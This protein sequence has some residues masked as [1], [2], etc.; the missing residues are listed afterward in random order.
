[1]SIL[2]VLA[3]K[4]LI[5]KE[6]IPLIIKDAQVS[7]NLFITLEKY[8][9]AER[10]Y[11]EAKGEYFGMPFIDLE[12][13]EIPFD[14]LSYVPEESAKFYKIAPIGVED[15]VLKIGVVDPENVE[16]QNAL[17]FIASRISMPVKAHLI[18]TEDFEKVIQSYKGLT[19]EVTQALTEIEDE[20]STKKVQG[21]EEE[22]SKIKDGEVRIV[23]QAP[24]TKIVATIIHYA[25]EGN[26]SDIHIEPMGEKVRVRFRVDGALSTS[27]VLPASVQDALSA[28]IKILSNLRLDE[29]RKPQD[30]R[31]SARIEG[32]KIDF[33]VSTLPV[34]YGEKVVMRILDTARGVKALE[35]M[36]LTPENLK[37]VRD[38]IDK[39]FGMIL[40]SGPTGS[41]KSTTLYSMLKE[42]DLESDNVMSLEDPVEYNIPGMNQSQIKP[43]IGY[44]FANGLRTSLR[45]DPDVIMVGEIRDKETAQLAVQAALTGHLVL[46]TI[47]TNNAAGVIPRLIDMGVDPFLIAP[48]LILAMA[49]RLVSMLHGEGKPMPIENSIKMMIDKSF[50]DLPHEFR[51]NIVIPDKIYEAKPTADCPKGTRGRTAVF[52][53]LEMNKELEQVIL[54]N[55]TEIEVMKIARNQG[56]LTMHEDALLKAFKG[57]IPFE[58][59]NKI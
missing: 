55:P 22:F 30:G 53:I 49:Q 16:T 5:K 8:N 14:I 29:K 40:I 9:V 23:E 7:G 47:H 4:K 24:V 25:T 6:D 10:D 56:M 50:Q 2:D 20:L 45:Q 57:K 35:D 39:P 52:E 1:M 41:G 11:L 42:L 46:S 27:L 37:K 51:K 28:R 17:T 18:K 32:R 26:A 44:T 43:E 19:G 38:A 33:R 13:T 48:T 3:G 34:Y 15:N 31:F 59:I 54:K 12:N 36:G 21:K 58:E